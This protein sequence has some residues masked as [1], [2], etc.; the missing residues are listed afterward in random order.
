MGFPSDKSRGSV[1]GEQHMVYLPSYTLAPLS[2]REEDGGP[3][4]LVRLLITHDHASWD[5]CD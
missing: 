2:I 5:A 1:G 3:V 4:V